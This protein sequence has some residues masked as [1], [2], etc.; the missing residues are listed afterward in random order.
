MASKDCHLGSAIQPDY[1]VMQI[2]DVCA[3]DNKGDSI[4]QVLVG[5]V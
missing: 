4:R 2:K 1:V 5:T 3:V